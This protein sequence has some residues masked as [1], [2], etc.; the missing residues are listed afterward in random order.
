[1]AKTGGDTFSA[2][3]RAAMRAAVKERKASADRAEGEAAALAAIA[4]MPEPDRLLGERVHAIV[5]AA[6]P[7]LAARTWYGMP[8]YANEAGKIICFFQAASK[9][10]ARY[11]TLGFQHDAGL[12]D[13]VMWPV[14]FALTGLTPDVED[15][16]A[17]LVRRAIG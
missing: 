3:E 5:K 8:A 15:R 13:G 14:A 1:M 16:I 4:D 12:D 9:F 6:A 11:A 17:Q 7:T 10:K 2:E